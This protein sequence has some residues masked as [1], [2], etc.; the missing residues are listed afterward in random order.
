MKAQDHNRK[1]MPRTWRSWLASGRPVGGSKRPW[2]ARRLALWIALAGAITSCGH[3][4]IASEGQTVQLGLTEYRLL[5]QSVSTRVGTL[6]LQVHNYGRLTHN[7]VISSNGQTVDS[8]KALW[9]GQ[10]ASL[11]LNLAPG[12]Y[13][14]GSTLMSDEALGLYGTLTVT[15]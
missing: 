5:P 3:T 6:T 10:S 12:S 7:L 13:S 14:I 11:A 4:F 9:P 1:V 15:H 8:T 2:R